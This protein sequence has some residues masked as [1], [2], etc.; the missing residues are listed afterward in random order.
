M[1]SPF[2]ST[3]RDEARAR[4]VQGDEVCAD[5]DGRLLT[6]PTFS[7]NEVVTRSPV[8]NFKPPLKLLAGRGALTRADE[9]RSNGS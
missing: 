9:D 7:G 2:D 3:V 6:R 1:R 4:R 5:V 8:V